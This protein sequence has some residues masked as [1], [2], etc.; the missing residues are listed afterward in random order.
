[1]GGIIGLCRL[2]EVDPTLG[3]SPDESF[4]PSYGVVAPKASEALAERR[5][6]FGKNEIPAAPPKTFLSLMWAAY[7]DQTLSKFSFT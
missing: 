6:T 2:L 5:L 7:N 1:M 4:D 3:L